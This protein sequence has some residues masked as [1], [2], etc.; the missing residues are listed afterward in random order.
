MRYRLIFLSLALQLSLYGSAPPFHRTPVPS[1]PRISALTITVVQYDE[2]DG[3]P[4]SHVT[5]LLQDGKGFMWFA[6]WNG[7]C[8]YDGYEFHTFKPVA[9]DGCA[10]ATDRIRD[11]GL[12]PDGKILCRVDDD[13]F[14]FD[15]RTCQFVDA[16]DQLA[17]VAVSADDNMP[18]GAKKYR[19]SQSLKSG[20]DME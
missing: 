3:V 7:L 16:P 18:N 10:M 6:T 13:H 14:L 5:Q 19:Q 2:E 20:H 1:H 4:A 11:I 9:G 17:H 8:R 15:P 12:L